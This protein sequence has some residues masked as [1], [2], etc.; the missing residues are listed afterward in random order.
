MQAEAAVLVRAD[1]LRRVD[2]AALEGRE[3]LAAR[4]E[5]HVDAEARVDLARRPGMRI[6]RPLKSATDLISF[7]NQ[8]VI[9]TPVF[10]Q[11]IATMPKGAYTSFQSASPPPS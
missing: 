7:L 3:D 2:H 6:L 4:K 1:E 5:L 10:P 8:P 9:C 11:G